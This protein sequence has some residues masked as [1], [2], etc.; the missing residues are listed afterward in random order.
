MKCGVNSIRR[1]ALVSLLLGGST[2][3]YSMGESDP[4]SRAIPVR[5]CLSFL[6]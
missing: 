6:L 4:F 2:V 1:M 3:R 5:L